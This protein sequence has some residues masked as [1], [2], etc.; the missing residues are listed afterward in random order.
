MDPF[1][2]E[3]GCLNVSAYTGII[4]YFDIAEEQRY[5][6]VV[7]CKIHCPHFALCRRVYVCMR[8]SKDLQAKCRIKS[9]FLLPN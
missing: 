1:I 2:Q 6:E 3:S 5:L 8:I 9:D 4:K 7:N